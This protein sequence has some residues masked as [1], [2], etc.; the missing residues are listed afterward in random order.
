MADV[1]VSYARSDK[2][3]VVPLVAAIEQS[4]WSV[5][6]DPEIAPGQE[7]DN[8]ITSELAAASAVVVVWTPTS[9]TSRWVRDE[10]REAADRGVLVP[11]RFSEARLPLDVRA[12]HTIDL[13]GWATML[14][15]SHARSCCVRSNQRS[16]ARPGRKRQAHRR[17]RA[18]PPPRHARRSCRSACCRSRT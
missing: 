8:L 2:A 4:G 11:A 1:F 5:W 12:I 14:R 15:A 18:R 16:V 9:V 6:W 13:D 10:A 7:F 3:L 17:R